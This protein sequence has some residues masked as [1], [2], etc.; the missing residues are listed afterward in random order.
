MCVKQSLSSSFKRLFLLIS[1]IWS[2]DSIYIS[3]YFNKAWAKYYGQSKKWSR[4]KDL[5]LSVGKVGYNLNREPGSE[6]DIWARKK[7]NK[8]IRQANTLVTSF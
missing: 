7:W 4:Q 1:L 5:E 6:S 2:K 8:R 3:N